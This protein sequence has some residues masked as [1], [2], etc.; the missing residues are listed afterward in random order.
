MA[1]ARRQVFTLAVCRGS[2]A[3][4]ITV[5]NRPGRRATFATVNPRREFSVRQL[6]ASEGAEQAFIGHRIWHENLGFGSRNEQRVGE[7][8]SYPELES[9]LIALG[10]VRK[11]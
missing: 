2:C 5:P 8:S 10:K 7:L 4:T 6:A 3:A 1:V 11:P 9:A